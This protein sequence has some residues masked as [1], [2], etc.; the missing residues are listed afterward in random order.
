MSLSLKYVN[1]ILNLLN[2][3]TCG[4]LLTFEQISIKFQYEISK[5]D[6]LR[7]G[8]ALVL[9]LQNR[10][11]TPTPQQRLIIF[12]LFMEMYRNEQQPIYMNPFAPV[13]LSVLQ[14]NRRYVSTI[15]KSYHWIIPPV[16]QHERSF[17]YL[18]INNNHR[19]LLYKTPDEI[20]QSEFLFN[21]VHL[22]NELQ[23]QLKKHIDERTQQI[24]VLVRCHLTALIDDPEIN[25]VCQKIEK[26]FVDW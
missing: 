3:D 9:L 23:Q 10:D 19:D 11:L 8:N 12:Y 5:S 2:E 20:L 21:D 18:L 1:L 13:L 14:P 6:Y 26:S 4:S 16:T 22:Q 17:I 15:E 24:P 25:N 7:V